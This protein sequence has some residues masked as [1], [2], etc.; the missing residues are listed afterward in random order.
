LKISSPSAATTKSTFVTV[1]AIIYIL[2]SSTTIMLSVFHWVTAPESF[3]DVF[4]QPQ[5]DLLFTFFTF[6]MLLTFVLALITLA[7]SV[8]LLARK[9]WSRITFISSMSI[10]IFLKITLI[11]AVIH[12]LYV[13]SNASEGSEI[14]KHA[15]IGFIF[16]LL[17]AFM[18]ILCV[19]VVTYSMISIV[20]SIWLIKRFMSEKIKHLFHSPNQA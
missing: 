20:I 8:G 19:G 1:I 5:D 12:E 18:T 10:N 6:F 2:L 4:K 16:T 11:I 7:S 14:R 13:M 17:E 9:Q 15:L 3:L